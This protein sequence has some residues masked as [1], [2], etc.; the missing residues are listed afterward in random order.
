MMETTGGFDDYDET[1]SVESEES[2]AFVK[3]S[4]K[5]RI[6]RIDSI[7]GDDEEHSTLGDSNIFNN[8]A[9]F[10]GLEG[11]NANDSDHL[12]NAGDGAE[13]AEEENGASSDD[14]DDT[15]VADPDD[16]ERKQRMKRRAFGKL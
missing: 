14:S 9:D 2:F 12:N 7:N 1:K 3:P 4:T 16:S 10:D 13:E 11:D 5:N 8:T 6:V 15:F